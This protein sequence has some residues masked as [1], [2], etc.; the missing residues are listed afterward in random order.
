MEL[1]ELAEVLGKYKAPTILTELLIFDNTVSEDDWFSEGF[2]FSIDKENHMFKTYSND[3]GFLNSLIQFAQADGTG[4]IYAFWINDSYK[5]L[6]EVPIVAF[7]SEGGYH[8]V[9]EN[10]KAL[11][12]I[13]TYDVEPMIDWDSINYFKNKED[14]QSSKYTENYK[15]WL[16]EKHQITA[17]D[18]ADKIVRSAKEKYQK[19]FNSWIGK[20]YSK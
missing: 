2:E 19:E 17:T 18:D 16:Q 9:S 11:F 4:S 6:D 20:Y 14:Y 8:I 10:I 5:N 7:G 3:G 1:S 12:M 15:D 13:L